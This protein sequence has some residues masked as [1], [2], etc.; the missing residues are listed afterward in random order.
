[1]KGEPFQIF[2]FHFRCPVCAAS[3]TRVPLREY[4]HHWSDAPP[5]RLHSLLCILSG[6]LMEVRQ[7]HPQWLSE[8]FGNAADSLQQAIQQLGFD[9]PITPDS[10]LRTL[11]SASL[12]FDVQCPVCQLP[13]G[14]RKPDRYFKGWRDAGIVQT[15]NLLYETGLI[16]WGILVSL[17]NWAS[18]SVLQHLDHL[19][20]QLRLAA[21]ATSLL[22][23]PQCGRPTTCLY[24]SGP[25]RN[26]FCRWCFD[27]GG[28]PGVGV[29]VS[30][31]M[32]GKVAVSMTKTDATRAARNSQDILPPEIK[33]GANS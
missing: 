22:E 13:P 19:R 28:G 2:M 21:N 26:G 29:T 15:A 6:A 9:R 3:P 25:R 1:M 33:Q 32:G 27:M 7:G 8:N 12:Y 30:I 11:A 5:E 18:G 31:Q 4:L 23:C 17:P 20:G 16:L 14:P 10:S 24:G